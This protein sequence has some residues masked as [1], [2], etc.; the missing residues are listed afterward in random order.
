MKGTDVR[1]DGKLLLTRTGGLAAITFNNPDK[2]NAM[3]LAMWLALGDI[4]ET[5]A[6]DD[7]LR[8]LTLEGAGDRAFVVGADISEFGETRSNATVSAAYNDAV[9]RAEASVQSMPVPTLAL[10]RGY[11]IG[12]GVGIAMRCD[13]RLAREDAQFAVTPARLGLGYGYDGVASLF[14]RLGHATTADLLFSGRKLKAEEALAKG[15]CDLVYSGD[16]FHA[17]CDTYIQQLVRNAPLT[18]RAAKTALQELA[19]PE[20]ER[21]PAVVEA[22]VRTCFDSADYQEGQRAFAE[23]RPPEFEGR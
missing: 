1:A 20:V 2:L 6:K 15:L 10:I 5:L 16:R 13:L 17:E 7:S 11:C 4:C 14:A 23:K 12:G 3:N 18:V 9:A 21:D 19:R 22:M 8:V